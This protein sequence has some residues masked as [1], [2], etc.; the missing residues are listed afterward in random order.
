MSWELCIYTT[1][2]EREVL[3][4]ESKLEAALESFS[5]EHPETDDAIPAEGGLGQKPPTPEQ[6]IANLA[7]SDTPPAAKLLE[8]LALCRATYE[9]RKPPAPDE[10]P[11]YVSI[12]SFLLENLA[13]CLIGDPNHLSWG[14]TEL[15][16]LSHLDSRGRLGLEPK[17][18][19]AP[20]A[21]KRRKERPGE[22]RALRILAKVDAARADPELARDLRTALVNASPHAR[23]YVTLLVDEGVLPDAAAKKKLGLDPQTFAA[24]ADEAQKAFE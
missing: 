5:E 19:P 24:A 14:E 11:L 7:S 21:V 20:P 13:P 8:R 6:L 16:S 23:A 15:K 3:R 2:S 1:L 22:L 10:S 12:L 17:A 4:V 18:E 9:I